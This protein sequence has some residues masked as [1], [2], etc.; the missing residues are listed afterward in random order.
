MALHDGSRIE[1][2]AENVWTRILARYSVIFVAAVGIP[3]ISWWLNEAYTVIKEMNRDQERLTRTI[4]A[5]SIKLDF[6]SDAQRAAVAAEDAKVEQI[7]TE[8][9][10][11]TLSRYTKEDAGRDFKLRD[12]VIEQHDR[13]IS[14]LEKANKANVR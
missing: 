1:K 3:F 7:R 2:V 10:E 12:Q 13:R 14:D 6:T 11:R 8:I 5:V 9:R 4:D